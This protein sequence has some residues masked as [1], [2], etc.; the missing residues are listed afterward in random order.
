VAEETGLI[1]PLG[2]WVLDAATRQLQ[3]WQGQGKPWRI[4]VNISQHQLRQPG[5]VAV[6]AGLLE[7]RRLR[8]EGLELEITESAAMQDP[9]RTIQTLRELRALGV[10]LAIDDFGT[11]YSSLSYLKLLP[12]QR[13]KLDRS[14]VKDIEQ[15]QQR[16]R[17]LLRHHRPGPCPWPRGG[18]RGGG[19]PRAS[20]RSCT[21]STAT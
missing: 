7:S 4:A 15:R 11:G 5:F 14:F 18:G 21:A 3:L 2:A 20:R 16:R 6:V 9:E 13:L 1:V 12:I 10:E 19:E 8:P 17:H